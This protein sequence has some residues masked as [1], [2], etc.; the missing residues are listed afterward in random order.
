MPVPA[1]LGR[2]TMIPVAESFQRGQVRES[3]AKLRGTFGPT[4]VEDVL[5]YEKF[6]AR[7]M[8]GLA[9]AHDASV[10]FAQSATIS[11]S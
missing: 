7:A 10:G 1:L 6:C 11:S 5:T 3:P 4:N 2:V 8:G 9:R